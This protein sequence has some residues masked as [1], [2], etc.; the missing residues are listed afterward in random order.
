MINLLLFLFLITNRVSAQ[1][2]TSS[3][4]A[5]L[6]PVEGDNIQ[7]GDL[8]CSAKEGLK[9][10]DSDYDSSIFGVISQ[11]SAVVLESDLEDKAQPI[12]TSGKVQVRVSGEE[13]DIVSGN[14]LTSSATQGV[15]KKA[16]RNGYVIGTALEDFAPANPTDTTTMLVAL[17]IH[18]TVAF[19]DDRSNL[20][21]V[22]RQGVSAPLLTPL[23]ALRYLLAAFITAIAFFLGFVYFGRLAKSAVDAIGRNPQAR[24]TIQ[25]TVLI[26]IFVIVLLVFGGMAISYLIL[27]L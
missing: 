21:S 15:A 23:S 25:I 24:R 2:V 19:T 20:F 8:V 7:D 14:L 27:A 16:I 11:N 10:C 9:L 12:V 13:G 6:Y 26:Q 4:V 5:I 1:E 22:L 18:A 3:G 17:N